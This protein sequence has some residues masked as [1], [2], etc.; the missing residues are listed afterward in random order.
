MKKL[1]IFVILFTSFCFIPGF[2][3]QRSP[4]WE[5]V[6]YAYIKDHPVCALCGTAKDLQIHHIKPFHLYPELELEP[7]N[8]IT[9]CVSKYWGF[10]CHLIAGHGGN[11]KYENTWILEDIEKLKVIGNPQY[12]KEHGD[13]DFEEYIKFMKKRTKKYNLEQKK[14]ETKF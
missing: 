10:S 9:L 7:E 5:N 11:F 8:L 2:S 6:R 12:I 13:A 4:E 3:D 1:F 14:D